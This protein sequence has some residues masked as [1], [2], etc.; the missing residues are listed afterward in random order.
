MTE[1]EGTSEVVK[2]FLPHDAMAAC[3]A[4]ANTKW[5]QENEDR[6]G[7]GRLRGRGAR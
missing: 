4:A 1:D 2:A 3:S 7:G 5:S 6:K